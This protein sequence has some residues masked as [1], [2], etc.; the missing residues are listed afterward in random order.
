MALVTGRGGSV[1][2]IESADGGARVEAGW[3][4]AA[5]IPVVHPGRAD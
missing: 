3:P 4:R 1:R 5:G 2:M